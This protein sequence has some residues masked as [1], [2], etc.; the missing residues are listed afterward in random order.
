MSWNIIVSNIQVIVALCG[1]FDHITRSSSADA[2]C[3]AL[4]ITEPF[5]FDHSSANED[6]VFATMVKLHD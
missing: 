4:L 3:R 2:V 1:V 5:F 6:S